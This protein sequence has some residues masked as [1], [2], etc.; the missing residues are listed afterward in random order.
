MGVYVGNNIIIP[1]LLPFLFIL[2][3]YLKPHYHTIHEQ[4]L[5]THTHTQKK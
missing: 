2:E 1:L 5:H 4:H 3:A